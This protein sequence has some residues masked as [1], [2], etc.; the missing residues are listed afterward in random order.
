MDF[1]DTNMKEL[2]MLFE[3]DDTISEM[4]SIVAEIKKYDVYDILAR[5]SGL[6]LMPQNQNK[7][8][9]LDGLIAVILRDK[10][11]EYS[12]NYKM[13]SGKFRRLIEQLNNTNLAM[14]IDP[15]ENTFVQ[16]IMLM[17][18]HTVFNG[19]DN[20]PAYN[21]Q[22][23]IDILFYY[24]NNFPEEYLQ[25]VGKV[26]MMVLEMSDELAYRINVR[27]TEIVS[28]E[29]KRVILPDSSRI[30]E[31][32]SYVVFDEQ[33]V[34]RSLKDYNDLLDDI[35]M[36]FGTGVI[37]SMS[38]RPFYCKPFIR[39]AKE[40]T[41]VLLNVSLLPV[42]VFFQS[43]RIAEEFEIK[44]K[45]VRRYNDYIWRDCNKSL[46]VLGHHKIRENLIGVELLNNDY[47]KERIVTVYNN[48]LMLVVFVCDDAYNYTKD[49]M[50]D[51][52]PDERHSLIFE[53]RVKYYCEKMQ[54]ATS[55]IDDFYCM[56]ILSGIGRGIGLKAINKL[57]LF[58]VIKLNP[59][60]LH[61]ISVNE[62]KEE[63]FL[64]RYIRAK[65]KLKTNMPN[66]F[67]ELNA[68]S[69][70]TSNEHSFYLSDDFNPSETILYIAPGDSVDYINQAIEK[71]NAILVESYEDGWKTRVE[72]CDKI[73]N[74]Y[75]ESEWG[76][77]KKSSICICFSN[78]NI[79]ITSDEIVEEL[80]INLYFS[81]MDTLSYW[82]AECKVII[83]NMEMY[84]TLYHFNV[85]LDGDKKT[86]YYAPTEDIALFD[87]VSIEGCG[88][89]YN[90]IWSPKA[91]GQMSCKTNA[92]EKE[93]CQIVLD[94]LKKNTFTPYDYTEDI[95]K[96]FDN[97]MKKKFFSSD[98]EVIPY[99]KPI[100]FGNNRIVHGED[101]DYLLDIIG[102]T[103]LETGKWGYGI[104]P[105]SDRTKIAN[106]VVGM[107][108]GMLQNEIQQLSPN[109]LVEIIYFDLEETL[110]RVMIVEKR[111]ACDLACYPE[112]EEQYM[113]DYNDLNRTS[114][115]LKF[116]MEYVAAK[117]PKGKKVLG[118]GKYEYILA[119]CSLIIDWAYK[120]DL[121]YYNIFNT[122][123]EILKS[124]RIGMKRN[125]FENMYQYGDMY[126]REQLYYN[127]SGDFRKKYTIY[128]EDY[129]TALDEAFLS[130]YGYTFGQFCNVIMGMIN[131]S[132]EREH[133]EVFVENTDSLIEYLLNFNIDLTSEVVTQVIGNISLTE[134]KDFLKLPSKFRKEDVYPWRFN[135]AYSF[136]RRP[137]IIRGDDVIWGN[138]QLYHMLLY[139]TN[140]IYDGRLSTKDN[141]MATLIGR[142]SDNR[143]RLFN[144]L[145]VDML[146]DMGVFRVEPN[147]K[148]INKKL[149]ADENGNTLGDID[150]LIIDG[151]M[152]HVYVAEVKDFNFS[153]N[154]YEI[155]AEYLR[156]FVDGEKKCYAT[157]HNR[158]VNWVRE[159]IEDLKM[160]YGLDN[161]AWKISGLFIVSEPL[162]STQVYRQDIE[163]IS[164]AELSVE[165]IRSIR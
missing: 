109:N 121:F 86:Y 95:K 81:I 43:L 91:F 163:V 45:V 132:N 15:N 110:Y 94:V 88:R 144:Q 2:E 146:S 107:L 155:Q 148:K 159:H 32:A 44:D 122:P 106:D 131:Y 72:S 100:V 134:R 87:L 130:D 20:T 119:I 22:M 99:L 138:R 64:P 108:F 9:L 83:E 136:N 157:K 128:Q 18:N 85:V 139:V 54:E 161:V 153:R 40:K 156:M 47:Y 149:I 23:L 30:K 114:L 105:D 102:K 140:L 133:D 118:I 27:G 13:S 113:K 6:N 19:I 7:S 56:V 151:E 31:F 63:N 90:L 51:E 53:E 158:R 1:F 26:I 34:Q 120:N 129:S 117:P 82:L 48:E 98:I 55:D 4:E 137:V 124:D 160:Q 135:R 147:V 162:I 65:S 50:H 42:F 123:I 115:A 112:K 152:H 127:S 66:L 93:L 96:I 24:Q 125:E 67:S 79:W 71:E 89:H 101:E 84:D 12:S 62:R 59:F 104:I 77:T 58:E 111:Y 5:I 61:C 143:G 145:I 68:V 78:C 21:L 16:N 8:I 60:E 70:Y 57:S 11:E 46:K 76:E 103:V 74:M 116:M 97:P 25:K 69:I 142:I 52:Y 164:K 17:D 10:E 36:P 29:G 80:D 154:P 35:I 38:N 28:D 37:G 92:K 39:N 14:S 126:R 73:R 49:T 165:R 41:I 141:K 75:T 33:R 150:V 3:D